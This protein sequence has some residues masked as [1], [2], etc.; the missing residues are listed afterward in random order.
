MKRI[1]AF[2]QSEKISSVVNSLKKAGVSGLTV[3]EAS[4]QGEGERPIVHTTRGT[5]T[6]IAEYNSIGSIITVVK[7]TMV[8]QVMSVIAKAAGTGSKKDG[9]IFVSPVVDLMDIGSRQKGL[10]ALEK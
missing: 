1:E 5:S 6:R 2:V 7:D 8:D 10:G 9:K 3:L 4:G